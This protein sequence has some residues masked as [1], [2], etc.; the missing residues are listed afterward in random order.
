MNELT[1]HFKLFSEFY[2]ENKILSLEDVM[3]VII[4]LFQN[5]TSF[6]NSGLNF[7]NELFHEYCQQF[8]LISNPNANFN[9][10]GFN[11]KSSILS[12]FMIS[13]NEDITDL[14]K[15]QELL[16]LIDNQISK[17]LIVF[18]EL[19]QNNVSISD[20][21][22]GL[23]IELLEKF[24][25]FINVPLRSMT[26]YENFWKKCSVIQFLLDIIANFI[27]NFNIS[28]FVKTIQSKPNTDYIFEML[29]NKINETAF[30]NFIDE[31]M[32]STSD[33]A[34]HILA[35]FAVTR[36]R[37]FLGCKRN[38]ALIKLCANFKILLDSLALEIVNNNGKSKTI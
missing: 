38:F 17:L 4:N 11:I 7:L 19:G 1:E 9:L 13:L 37:I 34:N 21:A 2:H 31:L 10:I 8:C 5:S 12:K 15:V 32:K 3:N 30:L 29:F 23:C 26:S 24:F 14:E 36:P 33:R 22:F 16:L 20:W 18:K 28:M 35:D 27:D 25:P 6:L